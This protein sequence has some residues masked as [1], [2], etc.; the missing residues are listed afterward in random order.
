MRVVWWRNKIICPFPSFFL[1]FSLVR[2]S[3]VV[4]SMRTEIQG[5]KY[6][7]RSHLRGDLIFSTF[8]YISPP[9]FI[10]VTDRVDSENRP[11][12]YHNSSGPGAGGHK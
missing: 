8:F 5:K 1:P 11:K 2:L 6:L 7:S 9:Q 12:Q 3:C 10:R 4:R